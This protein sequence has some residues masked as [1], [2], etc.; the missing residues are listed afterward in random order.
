MLGV[1]CQGVVIAGEDFAGELEA[2]DDHGLAGGDVA[3]DLL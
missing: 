1:E 3:G 2:T